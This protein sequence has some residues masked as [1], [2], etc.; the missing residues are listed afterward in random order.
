MDKAQIKN[1]IEEFLNKLTVSYTSVDVIEHDIHP[2]F[3][4][5]TNDSGV[6][7]GNGG[8]NLRAMNYLI[9]LMMRKEKDDSFQ[10][11]L[12]VN[13]YH[14]KRLVELKNQANIL[15]ERARMFKS[16]VEM[17]PMNAYERM[18]VHALFTNDSTITTESEGEGK[19]RRVVLKYI[20]SAPQKTIDNELK[21]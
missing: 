9:K 5:R 7:I 17:N 19:F 3:L 2:V 13:G 12:D 16:S 10:F 1:F 8:E 20:S 18:I 14:S 21:V 11:L 15:A 6:L 4:I